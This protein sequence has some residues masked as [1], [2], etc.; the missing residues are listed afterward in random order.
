MVKN[1]DVCYL[2]LWA[3]SGYW[4][5]CSK[6]TQKVRSRQLFRIFLKNVLQSLGRMEG[7]LL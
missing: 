2:L 4:N 5:S 3:V 7:V 6:T 1:W